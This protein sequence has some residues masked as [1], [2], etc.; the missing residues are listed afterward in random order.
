MERTLTKNAPSHVGEEILL[1]GWIHTRRDHGKLIYID[2]R[3]RWGIV[4]VVFSPRQESILKDADRLRSEWVVAIQGKVKERPKGMENPDLPTGS[5]EIEATGL[6]ILHEAET[7]PFA[8]D[9]D[10]YEIG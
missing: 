3:D 8:I 1:K 10:G 2:L 7:L 6:E 5:I 4:Q 9:T